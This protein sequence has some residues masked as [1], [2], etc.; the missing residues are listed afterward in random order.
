MTKQKVT[1]VTSR[2]V[3]H[4]ILIGEIL[5]GYAEAFPDVN[6]HVDDDLCCRLDEAPCST[7][8]CVDAP[9]EH[10]YIWECVGVSLNTSQAAE[11]LWLQ[12]SNAILDLHP[13]TPDDHKGSPVIRRWIATLVDSTSCFGDGALQPDLEAAALLRDGILPPGFVLTT[14]RRPRRKVSP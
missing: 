2:D 3:E 11:N 9:C 5:G 8:R 13:D 10:Q 12:T 14:S 7:C 1:K 6:V 4:A